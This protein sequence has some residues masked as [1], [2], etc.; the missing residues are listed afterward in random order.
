M[1]IWEKF[2]DEQLAKIVENSS[3]YREVAR[4]IGYNQDGGSSIAT[5][6]NL[7]KEKHFDISHFTG[8]AHNKNKY[9]YTRFQNGKAIKSTNALNAL[10]HLRGRKCEVC[11]LD[12]WNGKDIP[13]E[14]HH[15]DGNHLNNEL[16]NLQLLCCNCHAQTK[17][18]RRG[19]IRPTVNDETLLNA[20]KTTTSIRQALFKCGLTGRGSNYQRAYELAIKNGIKI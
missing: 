3:S 8:Q 1:K 10:A 2:T 5:I 9:D 20:L 6:K 4:K 16:N 15:K 13:L 11:N 17:N 19:N 7:I 12:S 18:F 14:I